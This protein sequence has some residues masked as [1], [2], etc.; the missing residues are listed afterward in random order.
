MY[1]VPPE[2]TVILNY[3]NLYHLRVRYCKLLFNKRSVSHANQIA[4]PLS[5]ALCSHL[6]KDSFCFTNQ[7]VP[8]VLVPSVVVGFYCWSGFF[9]YV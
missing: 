2:F 3:F 4:V 8:L 9:A 7:S 5:Q 1:L 6:V